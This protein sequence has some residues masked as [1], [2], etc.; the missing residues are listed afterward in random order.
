MK[1][2]TK[3]ALLTLIAAALFGTNKNNMNIR[4]TNTPETHEVVLL[5]FA[6]SGD[7]EYV[8]R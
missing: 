2:L 6:N 7:P 1:K 3:I 8:A 5:D 4:N